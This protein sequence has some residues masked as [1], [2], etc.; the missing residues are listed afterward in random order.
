[1]GGKVLV[2]LLVSSILGDI[3]EV[4][5]SDDDSVGH[6]GRVDDTVKD[7]ASNRDIA[8]EGA[9]LVDVGA[10]DGLI[11]GLETET[12]I[13]VPSLSLGSNLLAALRL[14]VLEKVLLLESFLGLLGHFDG[15]DGWE[16]IQASVLEM[17]FADRQTQ[18]ARNFAA[19]QKTSEGYM[20]HL[21]DPEAC[22]GPRTSWYRIRVRSISIEYCLHSK[23]TG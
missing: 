3:V 14:G 9:L 5:S 1:M 20:W 16:E 11:G 22:L 23:Y 4:L 18:S 6:L 15:F 19:F 17:T 7:S 10:V 13:L 8:S 21:F 2:S 12:D